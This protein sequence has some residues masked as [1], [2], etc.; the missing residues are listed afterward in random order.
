M[1]YI[2]VSAPEHGDL[3]LSGT[4]AALG[5]GARFSQLSNIVYQHDGSENHQ[6]SFTF[7]VGTALRDANDRLD[8]VVDQ[9]AVKTFTIDVNP[10][11]DAPNVKYEASTTLRA[12]EGTPFTL[13]LDTIFE[14]AEGD[15]ITYGLIT[16]GLGVS[17]WLTLT[18]SILSGTPQ[19]ADVT[20]DTG[21]TFTIKATDSLGA[22]VSTT[23]TLI[24]DDVNVAPTASNTTTTGAVT[25]DG[26]AT[27]SGSVTLADGDAADTVASLDVRFTAG[28]DP[29]APTS[30]SPSLDAPASGDPDASTTIA[31]A[32]GTFT[33]SRDAAGQVTWSY[34][35]DDTIAAVQALGAGETLT[36]TLK[37]IAFD[38]ENPTPAASNVETITVTINGA[39]DAPTATAS[40]APAGGH[41]VTE[42][43]NT[44]ATGTITLADDDDDTVTSLGVAVYGDR[45]DPT[46]SSSSV[47]AD[48]S[49]T[50]DGAYGRFTISRD[51]AG[52]VTWSYSQDDSNATVNALGAGETLTDTLKSGL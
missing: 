29:A 22:E 36:D 50:I 43:G 49:T 2:L 39:N 25:E 14:D 32:Y 52:Q 15:A 24:V 41:Q 46:S 9:S 11:N 31:G 8:D 18:G 33:V 20:P 19:E 13:D 38:D 37:L 1:Y 12:T 5:A 44:E 35:Q 30:T 27:A 40:P 28:A 48:G 16:F 45:L 6:D 51:A 7:R 21:T 4:T 26:T 34:R 10:V 42:D 3:K 23:F 47:D 17:S